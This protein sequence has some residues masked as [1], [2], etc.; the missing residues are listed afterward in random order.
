MRHQ[1]DSITMEIHQDYDSASMDKVALTSELQSLAIASTGRSLAA[2]FREVYDDVEAALFAG[3]R[4]HA[5]RDAL[6]RH[7]IDI[8]IRALDQLLYRERKSR[9]VGNAVTPQLDHAQPVKLLEEGAATPR[10]GRQEA[11]RAPAAKPSHALAAERDQRPLYVAPTLPDDW[12]TGKLTPEQ[13]KSLT[14]AQRQ[15]R[16][17]AQEDLYFPNP[18]DPLP[19]AE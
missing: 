12:M 7:G 15:A 18:Y 9:R 6:A 13:A 8:P 1:Y 3:V 16:R 19:K 10:S 2:R 14:P 5:I 11:T 4:R 17:K